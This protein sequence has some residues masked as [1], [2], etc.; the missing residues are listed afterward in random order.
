VEGLERWPG[1]TLEA[2]AYELSVRLAQLREA[3]I[4][5]A[6]HQSWRCHYRSRYGVCCCGLDEL[7]ARLG[8]PT[9]EVHDPEGEKA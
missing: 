5:Y 3:F 2:Q 9:V 4:E 6:D 1:Y 7:T 8:L